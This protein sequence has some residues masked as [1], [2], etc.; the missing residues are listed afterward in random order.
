MKI[1]IKLSVMMKIIIKNWPV[2]FYL[3]KNLWKALKLIKMM[4]EKLLIKLIWLL[5]KINMKIIF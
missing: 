2:N 4:Q 5:D 3:V 1:K